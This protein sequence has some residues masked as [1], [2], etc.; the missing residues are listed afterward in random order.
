MP[1]WIFF[2]IFQQFPDQIVEFVLRKHVSTS[3]GIYSY[4]GFELQTT[5]LEM[6]DPLLSW[7][8]LEPSSSTANTWNSFRGSLQPSMLLDETQNCDDIAMNLSCQ[9]HW[10]DFGGYLW[11]HKT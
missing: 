10:E 4:G 5:V 11:N 3:S 6:S 2:L 9:A 8:W 7:S 1:H